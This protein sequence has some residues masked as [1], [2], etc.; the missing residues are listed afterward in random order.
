VVAGFAP[1]TCGP[2]FIDGDEDW[3]H[4]DL[5]AFRGT[6]LRLRVY[7]RWDAGCGF[8]SVDHAYLSPE[9]A[10]PTLRPQTVGTVISSFEDAQAMVANGWVALGAFADPQS[11]DAWSGT[12]RLSN[13][14]AVR[15]GRGAVSTCELGEGCDQPTGELYSPFFDVNARYLNFAMSGGG[16]GGNVPV[17]VEVLDAEENVLARFQPD[18]CGPS[19]INGRDDWHHI[20]LDAFGGASVQLRIYDEAPGGCGFLSFDHFFLSDTPEGT[21]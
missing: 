8:V 17:G 11:P 21:P 16:E 2:S 1:T 14:E 5:D 10:Y 3:R 7:D 4:I 13:L 6:M 15:V 12:A 20:D 18:N 19:H 9:P